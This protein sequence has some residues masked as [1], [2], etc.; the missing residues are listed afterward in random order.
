MHGAI[1]GLC[2]PR[3]TVELALAEQTFESEGLLVLP[4]PSCLLLSLT[5]DLKLYGVSCAL[6]PPRLLT[7]RLPPWTTSVSA[8]KRLG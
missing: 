3:G 4:M 7:R 1:A 2:Q 6:A 8:P 5:R